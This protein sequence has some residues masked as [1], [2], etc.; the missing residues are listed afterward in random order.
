MNAYT[1]A[2]DAKAEIVAAIE[3]SGVVEDASTEYDI[4]AIF[5]ATYAFDAERQVFEQS[6]D[7]DGF[8]AAVEAHATA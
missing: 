4:D 6:V 1:T 5:D 7:V 2:N 8:W 3:A